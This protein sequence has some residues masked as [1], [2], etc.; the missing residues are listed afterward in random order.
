M[1]SSCALESALRRF[2]DQL[3]HRID[4]TLDAIR[5]LMSERATANG[6]TLLLRSVRSVFVIAL[7]AAC[8]EAMAGGLIEVRR[9]PKFVYY[10]GFTDSYPEIDH[11]TPEEAFSYGQG[12]LKC[13]RVVAHP[14]CY[15]TS[16]CGR[17]PTGMAPTT[18]SRIGTSAI[19]DLS[20]RCLQHVRAPA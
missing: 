17:S 8:T 19:E 2:A 9:E 11:D 1:A 18:E 10:N 7:L 16:T 5:N 20:E 6:G 14:V 12:H 13:T 3:S 15:Y 4:Y